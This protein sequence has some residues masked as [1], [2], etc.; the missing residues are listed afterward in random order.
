MS[1]V[2]N[3]IFVWQQIEPMF[4]GKQYLSHCSCRYRTR[5]LPSSEWI[6]ECVFDLNQQC[7]CLL[8]YI[9][10]N[11]F[12]LTLSYWPHLPVYVYRF[13]RSPESLGPKRC[14]TEIKSVKSYLQ[15]F[16]TWNNIFV[17]Q[18]KLKRKVSKLCI[19]IFFNEY[20]IK[21]RLYINHK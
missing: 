16:K 9:Q 20:V 21:N 5:L 3:E 6:L 17:I 4:V 15:I 18:Q 12:L 7:P 13:Q 2:F 10:I 1:I 14:H 19:V 8:T 11:G